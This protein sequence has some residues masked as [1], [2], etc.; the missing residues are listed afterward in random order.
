MSGKITIA[1]LFALL[2][3]VGI[4]NV[5]RP[6]AAESEPPAVANER[7][8]GISNQ[9]GTWTGTDSGVNLK[10]MRVA[11]AEAYLSRT[12]ANSQT[13]EA[14][15]VMLLYGSPGDLGAHDPKTCYA[16]TGF[17]QAGASSRWPAAGWGELW[18]AQFE[19]TS[20]PPK[21]ALE[22]FWAWGT[23]GDWS[24]PDQPRWTFAGEGRIYKLYVQRAV[25][26]TDRGAA[27]RPVSDFLDP[28]LR[29]LKT[30]LGAPRP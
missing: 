26:S 15:S 30:A 3:G 20:P 8:T 7:L 5:L 21:A 19:R 2:A 13:N 29:E 16:G 6:K 23:R 18:T 9:L 17:E 11:E 22:V 14:Y 12:Y 10:A 25:S 27:P 24:A 1:A 4:W 28:L